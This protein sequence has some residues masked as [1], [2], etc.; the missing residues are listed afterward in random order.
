MVDPAI[1]IL[2][3]KHTTASH[4]ASFH[5]VYGLDRSLMVQYFDFL[6]SILSLDLGFSWSAKREITSMISDGLWPSLSITLPIFLIGNILSIS[7]ALLVTYHRGKPLD[8]FILIISIA[9]MSIPSLVY[10]LAGQYFFAYKLNW[11]EIAGFERSFVDCIPY[12]ILPVTLGMII[13]WGAD[14]RFYRTCIVDEAYKDYVTTARSKG[15]SEFDILFKHIL[16]NSL[17]PI[18]TY[19]IIQIPFLILGMFLFESFFSIPGLGSL[20]INAI[21][22][23]DLPVIKAMTIFSSFSYIAFNTLTD[24][25]YVYV[26]PRITL[27]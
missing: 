1:L 5:T 7:T 24:L 18:L 12:I 26:D 16:K 6:K 17:I 14:S 3:P 23:S 13:N 9:S 15:V 10:V 11:F 8:K 19:T 22:K 4:I 27:R 21:G 20:M 25:L 2:G